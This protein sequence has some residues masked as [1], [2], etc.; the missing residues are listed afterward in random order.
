MGLCVGGGELGAFQGDGALIDQGG[1]QFGLPGGP[2]R[3]RRDARDAG[4]AL[5]AP[6][7]AEAPAGLGQDVRPGAGFAAFAPGP[8]GGGQGGG[9]QGLQRRRPGDGHETTLLIQQDNRGRACG[10]GHLLGQNLGRI[11]T[12]GGGGEAFAGGEQGA[13]R[14]G[15]AGGE[16]GVV[17]G[18]PGQP[19]GDRRRGD[20][21]REGEGVRRAADRKGEAR[22][23][24]EEVV[25][26]DGRG[27]GQQSRAQAER[28]RADKDAG[29][30]QHGQA[31]S[32]AEPVHQEAGRCGEPDQG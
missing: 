21:D 9:A 7:R 17:A 29:Q 22:I 4:E 16:T 11:V 30:E 5:E 15:A 1:D 6:Q 26:Q 10:P 28:D 27:R 19:A 8:A 13:H 2:A 12:R 20:E 18:A 14:R 23:E 25:A 32:L 3:R 24:E 31:R